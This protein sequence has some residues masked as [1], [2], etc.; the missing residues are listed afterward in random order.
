MPSNGE[1]IQNV[2]IQFQRMQA[3]MMNARKE[4]ATITYDEL[5]KDYKS[6]KAILN[7]MGVNLAEIDEIKE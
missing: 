4:N 2:V 1:I 7:S 6:L 5:K 3:H